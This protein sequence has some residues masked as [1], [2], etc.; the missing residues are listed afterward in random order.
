MNADY[1]HRLNDSRGQ[2]IT[3]LLEELNL[4]YDIKVYFRD[5]NKRAPP[6][7]KEVNPLGKSPA[8]TVETPGLEKPLVLAESGAIVEYLTDHFGKHLI[9]KRY[10]DGSDGLVGTE[11]KEWIRYRVSAILHVDPS[12]FIVHFRA[13]IFASLK[14]L[15]PQAVFSE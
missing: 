9:P 15:C 4:E 5:K 2:R 6:E 3:W 14:F 13:C 8:I 11:T 12:H 1:I 7:L 10:P